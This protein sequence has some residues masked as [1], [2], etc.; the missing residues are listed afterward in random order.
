MEGGVKKQARILIADDNVDNVDIARARLAAHNYEIVTATDGEEA[1][2]AA[3]ELRPDLILL[4]VMMPRMDGIE[5][6]RRVKADAGL[7]FIPV[8]MVTARAGTQ[9][10]VAAL[11]AGA[12]EYLTK[13]V[14][15]AALVARVNSMLRIKFLT[16]TVEEQRAKL[17]EWARTL[18]KRVA[19][20]V[21]ELERLSQLRRFFSPQLAEAILKGGATDPL[22]SHRRE[23]IVV[24]LDLRGFTTFAET[25]E[26]EEVMRLLRDYHAEQDVSSSSTRARSSGSPAMA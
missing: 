7:P 23:I 5:V 6:C 20:Q 17:A 8:I 2:A 21:D 14:D 15:H 13:P 18:E 19:E 3:R 1:L 4:D 25:S 22:L 26:P 9:D 10:I 16:D 12:D 24:F 11:K